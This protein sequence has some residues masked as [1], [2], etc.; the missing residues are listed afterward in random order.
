MTKAV[1]YG[2]R[3]CS[4]SIDFSLSCVLLFSHSPELQEQRHVEDLRKKATQG[5]PHL[6]ET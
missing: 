2:Q 1:T 3:P 6:P 5:L 4:L